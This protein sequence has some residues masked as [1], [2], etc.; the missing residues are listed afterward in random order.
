MATNFSNVPPLPPGMQAHH[1]LPQQLCS[2]LF[3][4]ALDRAGLVPLRDFN[5]NG[6][7]LPSDPSGTTGQSIHSGPHPAYNAFA[8]K[9][10]KLATGGYDPRKLTDADKE[11]IADRIRP[12][13]DFLRQGLDGTLPGGA[14]PLNIADPRTPNFSGVSKTQEIELQRAWVRQ[15]YDKLFEQVQAAGGISSIVDGTIYEKL[16]QANNPFTALDPR[17]APGSLPG[18]SGH[19]SGKTILDTPIVDPNKIFPPLIPGLPI[20]PSGPTTLITPGLD[21]NELAKLGIGPGLPIPPA[22]GPTIHNSG[23]APVGANWPQPPGGWPTGGIG[24]D[25]PPEPGLNSADWVFGLLIPPAAVGELAVAAGVIGRG[26]IGRFASSE[27]AGAVAAAGAKAMQAAGRLIAP[28]V[29][30]IGGF[31]PKPVPA[32]EAGSG[33]PAPGSGETAATPVRS[34]SGTQ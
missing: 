34:P 20:H 18:F 3:L 30:P 4:K 24:P 6:I 26:V 8:D 27:A 17:D 7:A 29:A 9:L 10:V 1:L 5:T 14:W 11:V 22:I 2:D 25:S 12:V 16:R 28:W 31:I 21:P 13:Q 23:P 15:H 32:Q 33:G 19:R